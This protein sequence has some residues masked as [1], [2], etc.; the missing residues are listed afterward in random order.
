MPSCWPSPTACSPLQAK[1][2]FTLPGT[3]GPGYS[4]E[5]SR[6]GVSVQ[7][8]REGKGHGRALRQL[9]PGQ[10]PPSL[11]ELKDSCGE[12]A[13]EDCPLMHT[14]PSVLATQCTRGQRG[15]PPE[16]T[17]AST[18]W[19]P[20]PGLGGPAKEAGLCP[21]AQLGS[22]LISRGNA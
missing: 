13:G 6:L 7:V 17:H 20:L 15:R 19:G 12:G 1:A 3:D 9:I 14:V 18:I 5:F 4:W 2:L 10:A 16:P 21:G 11:A 8:P 22:I